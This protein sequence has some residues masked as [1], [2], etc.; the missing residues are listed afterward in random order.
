MPSGSL[1]DTH[2][3]LWD[4]ARISYAW[5]K[6]NT[7]LNRTYQIEDY[8]RDSQGI[9]VEAMVFVECHVDDGPGSVSTS[10]RSS[11]SKNKPNVIRASEPSWP[12]PLSK[13]ARKSRRFWRKW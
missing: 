10:K 5:Q 1:I 12:K 7:L 4:P 9:D 2:L 11:L 13:E 6:G 8:Q 3:H